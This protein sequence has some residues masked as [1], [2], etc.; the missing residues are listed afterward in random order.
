MKRIEIKDN[1]LKEE[2]PHGRYLFKLIEQPGL[3][4]VAEAVKAGIVLAYNERGKLQGDLA[5]VRGMLG[6]ADL[7]LEHEAT[8]KAG[9]VAALEQIRGGVGDPAV[10]VAHFRQIAQRALAG[11]K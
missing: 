11:A 6:T 4:D 1:M 9:L 7:D 5:V 10:L 8:I 2:G 3:G